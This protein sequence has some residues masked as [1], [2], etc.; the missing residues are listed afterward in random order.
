MLKITAIALILITLQAQKISIISDASEQFLEVSCP[1]PN[2]LQ[3]TPWFDRDDTSGYG[4]YETLSDLIKEGK[5]IC[6]KPVGIQCQTTPK[7]GSIPASLTGESVYIL[8]NVG[9]YCVNAQQPDGTCD[10]DYQVRF[11]CCQ[12][13]PY[14]QNSYWT[15]WFDRDN[16][17]GVGDYEML[18]LLISEGNAICKVPID[19]ECRT[20]NGGIP[21]SSTG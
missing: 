18:S 21:A 3:W 13:C 5:P 1:P 16:T 14:G 17:G 20:K 7:Y 12:E 15:S 2:S 8:A 6:A 4:D 9:C 19:V 11:Q 10:Y